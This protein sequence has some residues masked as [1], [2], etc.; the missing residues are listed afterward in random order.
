MK[1]KQQRCQIEFD[2]LVTDLIISDFSI[3]SFGISTH[4]NYV[5]VTV[6][7]GTLRACLIK[8][9]AL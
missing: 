3:E 8:L 1:I 4:Q 6:L 7:A 5:S 2:R 9:E